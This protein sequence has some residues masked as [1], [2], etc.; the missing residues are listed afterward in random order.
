MTNLDNFDLSIITNGIF[1]NPIKNIDN[2]YICKFKEDIDIVLPQSTIIKK[3]QEYIYSFQLDDTKFIK[4]IE[5]LN[6][7]DNCAINNTLDNS[8]NWFDKK[9]T[10]E[11][12]QEKYTP[13]YNLE[14]ENIKIS[15]D[16]DNNNDT[17][18]L[19]ET[20]ITK[21]I[22]L[23]FYKNKFRFLIKINNLENKNRLDFSD[24]VNSN[25]TKLPNK[26]NE[27]VIN[28]LAINDSIIS[29][30]TTLSKKD[31]ESLISEK[32]NYTKQCFIQAEK[33]GQ[34]AENLRLKAIES[35]NELKNYEKTY[36][37]YS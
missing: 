28:D 5:L 10:I 19:E 32:R 36:E 8:L 4:L 30:K 26:I 33:I 35:I 2:T 27:D 3:N 13:I 14:N 6:I 21:I 15:F 29:T 16:L 18:N 22:G 7:L 20:I 12:L 25:N 23:Q 24:I 9:I 34:A 11:K 37:N 17:I 1:E 31:L